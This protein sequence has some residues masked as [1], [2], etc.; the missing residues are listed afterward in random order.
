MY[1]VAKDCA[2]AVAAG[3]SAVESLPPD[4]M[5]DCLEGV[6]LYFMQYFFVS[7]AATGACSISSM[8]CRIRSFAYGFSAVFLC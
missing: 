5:H 7:V 2:F 1:G 6:I 3:F 8:N 4:I